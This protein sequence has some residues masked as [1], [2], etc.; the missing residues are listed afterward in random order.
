MG[1]KVTKEQLQNLLELRGQKPV[2]PRP[3]RKVREVRTAGQGSWTIVLKPACRV[4]TESNTHEHWAPKYRRF[5]AQTDAVV[6]VLVD[7][8]IAEFRLG[9]GCNGVFLP[10]RPFPCVITLTHIWPRMDDDN[11]RGAFKGVRDALA[12]ALRV[13]DADAR[14]VWRCDQH[15]GQPGVVTAVESTEV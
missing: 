13:D 2:G 3:K 6:A 4:V 12:A 7:A 8:G 10:G 1:M 11:L 15:P 5:K 14:V 9:C